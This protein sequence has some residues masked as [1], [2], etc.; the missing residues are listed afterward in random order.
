MSSW[1][2]PHT[3]R[4]GQPIVQTGSLVRWFCSRDCAFE[5]DRRVSL[6]NAH[7]RLAAAER[8]VEEARERLREMGWTA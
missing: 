3:C 6:E 2:P 1:Q 7:A 8:E 5:D 4:C